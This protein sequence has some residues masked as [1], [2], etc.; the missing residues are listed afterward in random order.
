MTSLSIITAVDPSRMQFLDEARASVESLKNIASRTVEWVVS[1]DGPADGTVRGADRVIYA[2]QRGGVSAAR[3]LALAA[4]TGNIIFTLDADDY[5]T[6]SG[7]EELSVLL[8]NDESLGWVSGNCLNQRGERT[9]HWV[10]QSRL[11]T[12]GQLAANWTS[13]FSFHP[14]IVL[15]RRSLALRIGGWPGLRTNEDL[16]FVMALARQSPGMSCTQVVLTYRSWSGQTHK[17]PG[18]A[19]DKLLAFEFITAVENTWRQ[20]T[21]RPEI[22]NPL[23]Q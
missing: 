15:F 5:L 10:E 22:R 20:D 9:V 4:A 17:G 13:P 3:N 16:A 6:A 23:T 2:G 7:V 14:N 21:G 19:A 1:V 11:W 12:P 18:W 8:S